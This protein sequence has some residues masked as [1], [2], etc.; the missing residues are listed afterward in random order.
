MIGTCAV[1]GRQIEIRA[2]GVCNSCYCRYLRRGRMDLLPPTLAKNGLCKRGHNLDEVGR[3]QSGGCRECRR[4]RDR[5]RKAAAYVPTPRAKA[6]PLPPAEKK[7]RKPPT[8]KAK[9]TGPLPAGWDRTTPAKVHPKP[10]Q[11]G[12]GGGGKILE[13]PLTPEL[14]AAIRRKAAARLL[15][16]GAADLLAALGLEDAA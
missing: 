10:G 6:Q 11:A 7:P 4:M 15:A 9:P 8:Q 1:C 5:D 2:R 12:H 13:V 3:C 14:P 16:I